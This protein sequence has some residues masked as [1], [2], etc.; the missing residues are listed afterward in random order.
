[1]S[2]ST[3]NVAYAGQAVDATHPLPV[4]N[5]TSQATLEALLASIGA[6]GDAAGANTV[7]GQL[8]QIAINTD[9]TP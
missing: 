8:K 2:Q 1:M 3:Q 9:L 7:I 5:T 4:T 6:P